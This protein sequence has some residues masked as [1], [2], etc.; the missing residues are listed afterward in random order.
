M[1]SMTYWLPANSAFMLS[2]RRL[3]FG[4]TAGLEH[5]EHAVG[6]E[7][8]SNHIAGGG[9]D[10]DHAQDRRKR[11]LLF[12]DEDDGTD[13]GD[14]VEGVGERHQRR[15]EQ[16]RDVADDFEAD[17]G[18][19]HEYEEGVDD[20]GRHGVS[21]Q[22]SVASTQIAGAKAGSLKNSRTRAFTISP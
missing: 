1:I 20:V 2:L 5:A 18:C 15:V 7:K 6:D 11:A 9:D 4:G 8:S 17:E 21:S 22:F 3:R 10:G 13:D 16:G 19:E 14:G 12:A